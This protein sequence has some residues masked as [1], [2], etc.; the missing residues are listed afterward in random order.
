MTAERIG[1]V[2]AGDK[3]LSAAVDGDNV[4]RTAPEDCRVMSEIRAEIDRLDRALVALIAERTQFIA[5]AARVKTAENDVRVEWRIEDV[6]AK[7]LKTAE[8]ENLP[9]RIAE[10]VWRELIE[11]SI[12]FEADEWRRIRNR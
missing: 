9:A 2:A 6:V 12:A 8:A 10:P 3:G 5:A 11:Q 7:V 1:D 4:Q